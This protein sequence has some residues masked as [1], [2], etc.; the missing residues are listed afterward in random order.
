[1]HCKSTKFFHCTVRPP[2]S[3]QI[4]IA[5]NESI[6]FSSSISLEHDDCS[7][8]ECITDHSEKCIVLGNGTFKCK[9]FGQWEG[10]YCEQ[11]KSAKYVYLKV[12]GSRI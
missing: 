9:C 8:T 2:G 4:A 3:I 10:T 12:K 7:A 6:L 11:R 5:E 1:M